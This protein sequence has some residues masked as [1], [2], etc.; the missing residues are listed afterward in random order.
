MSN[1]LCKHGAVHENMV[2]QPLER[3]KH[4]R[5]SPPVHLIREFALWFRPCP[6]DRLLSLPQLN[7]PDLCSVNGAGGTRVENI[8][9][10][11]LCFTF[12][13]KELA[14]IENLRH[15]HAFAYLKLRRP[16][17]GKYAQYVLFFG[18][19]LLQATAEAAGERVRM[20]CKI[21]SRGMPSTSSKHFQIFN[22][23]R[24]G[25]RDLAVWCEELSRMGRGIV[26]PATPGLDIEYLLME[27]S[28]LPQPTP[29]TKEEALM[30]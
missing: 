8:S 10:G 29:H 2:V 21:I 12:R 1:F 23:E 25:I 18:V 17:P 30:A 6:E 20:R 19:T 9:A 14:G 28:A 11:G 24:A 22:V 7:L 16:L 13:R 26:P 3:R 5:V 27:L 4:F 15:R